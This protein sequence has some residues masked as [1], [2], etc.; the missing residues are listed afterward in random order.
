V[1]EFARFVRFGDLRFPEL[2]RHLSHPD[3]GGPCDLLACP[4]AFTYPTGQAHWSLLLS[5]RAVENQCYM[6]APAQG[7]QHDNGR[8]TWGHSLIADPWGEVLA[9]QAEGEGVVLA[10]LKRERIDQVRRQLPALTHRVLG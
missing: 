2:Y 4:A 9:E 1:N 7:G 8:R 6:L 5:T 3:H 10:E